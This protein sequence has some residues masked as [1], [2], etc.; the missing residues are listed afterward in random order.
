MNRFSITYMR[1][2]ARKMAHR[3]ITF[4]HFRRAIYH[5]I[6]LLHRRRRSYVSRASHRV[7]SR[8]DDSKQPANKPN[9]EFFNSQLMRTIKIY[10]RKQ[11]R[12]ISDLAVFHCVPRSSIVRI[13]FRIGFNTVIRLRKKNRAKNE[14]NKIVQLNPVIMRRSRAKKFVGVCLCAIVRN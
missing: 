11:S 6:R 7:I 3:R 13:N 14:R 1:A 4:Y 10:C 2:P 5:W 8:H 12:F 9:R